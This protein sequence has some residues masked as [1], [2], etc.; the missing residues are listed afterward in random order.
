MHKI[1]G[2]PIT[3]TFIVQPETASIYLPLSDEEA[4]QAQQQLQAQQAAQ[5]KA[6]K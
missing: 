4:K 1:Y 5:Q 6:K 2:F 3:R